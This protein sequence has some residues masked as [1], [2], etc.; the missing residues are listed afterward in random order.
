[1]R[2]CSLLSWHGINKPNILALTLSA[3]DNSQSQ[4]HKATTKTLITTTMRICY[5]IEH[6]VTSKKLIITYIK[7]KFVGKK[8]GF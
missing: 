8:L 7:L 2:D 6:Q 3:D 4:P 5:F 1:M